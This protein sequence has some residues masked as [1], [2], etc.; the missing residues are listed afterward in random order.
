MGSSPQS[1]SL[2]FPEESR[3]FLR[4][5]GIDRHAA[6]DLESRRSREPGK[7][8]DMPK[9]VSLSDV[10]AG[11]GVQNKIEVGVSEAP[12]ELG[13]YGLKDG[14]ERPEDLRAGSAEG[15]FADPRKDPD[16]EGVMGRIGQDG[17]K[18]RVRDEDPLPRCQLLLKEDRVEAATRC[19]EVLGG[20]SVADP[21]EVGDHG[22]R[23][24]LPVGMTH[25]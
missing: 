5:D 21:K 13:K 12:M 7:D 14:G 16:F 2:H 10:S 9:E 17:G 18:V 15:G 3:S 20:H 24:H 6:P 25:G 23:N 1:V 22:G 11:H 4:K 19:V 8:L